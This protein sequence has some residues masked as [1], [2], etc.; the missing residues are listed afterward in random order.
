MHSTHLFLHRFVW[1]G[2][3]WLRMTTG[4]GELSTCYRVAWKCRTEKCRTKLQG[5]TL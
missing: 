2:F 5:W 4:D 3:I 1:S